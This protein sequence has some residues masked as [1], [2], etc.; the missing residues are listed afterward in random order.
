[1]SRHRDSAPRLGEARST[2]TR[3]SR[4]AVAA[5]LA[6]LTLAPP[7]R[8][9]TPERVSGGSIFAPKSDMQVTTTVAGTF[10]AGLSVTY[11]LTMRNNGP[12]SAVGPITV[13]NTLPAGLSYSSV[14]SAAYTCSTSLQVATCTRAG[15]F[16]KGVNETITIVAL[17]GAAAGPT[18]TNV[19]T[20]SYPGNDDSDST[21]DTATTTSNVY[22][23]ATTPDAATVSKLPSNGTNYTQTFVVTN[24]GGASDSYTVGASVAPAGIVT[25]ISVAPAST[26]SLLAN[27]TANIVVTYS[28]ATGAATGA[29]AKITLTATST[30]TAASTDPGDLTVT[31]ARAGITMTKALYRD[32]RTTLVTGPSGVSVGEYVQYKVTVTNGGGAAA[33]AVSVSDPIP[34]QV[35]YDSAS[36][37]AA[38]WTIATA[39][40]TLTASLAAPLPAGTSRF[41]WIRVRVK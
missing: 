35:T 33:S 41:F 18:V 32:D 31:V 38:G 8:A 17:V 39:A 34:G 9:V 27:G 6:L 37:D 24:T 12:Q 10:A 23:V 30:F 40:G 25:V 4:T 26:G 7:A 28:V 13:V 20:V 1:M 19:A 16:V 5:A 29:T 22:K 3:A 14:T 2:A 15:T 11:T 36:P 21:N